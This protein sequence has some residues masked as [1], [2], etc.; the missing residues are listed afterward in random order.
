MSRDA[1]SRH[2]M[3]RT[4]DAKDAKDEGQTTVLVIG[5]S[6]ICLLLATVILAVTTI[7]LEARKLLSAADGA[8]MA[9]ADSFTMAVEEGAGSGN[10]PILDDAAAAEAVTGYLAAAGAHG[11]FEGLSVE[12][13]AVGDGGQTVDVVLSATARPPVVNW[14]VPE[15]V[16]VVAESSSR[17][18]LTR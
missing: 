5:L 3:R 9:A 15:G 17:T 18:A 16:T 6:I 4:K 2:A 8:T 11:R 12:S 7:N 1:M 13:V 14:I 10:A